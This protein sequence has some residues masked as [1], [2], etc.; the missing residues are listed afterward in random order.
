MKVEQ[1]VAWTNGLRSGDYK[2]IKLSFRGKRNGEFCALGVLYDVD[3]CKWLNGLPLYVDDIVD[4][5]YL[6]P[7]P[8]GLGDICQTMIAD[9]NDREEWSFNRIADFLDTNK[10][11]FVDTNHE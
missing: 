9:L 4:G 7:K 8:A 10:E 2:Q 11:L 1:L 3:G 6:I 5:S